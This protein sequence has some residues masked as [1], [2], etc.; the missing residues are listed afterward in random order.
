[1]TRLV[2]LDGSLRP[3][4]GNTAQALSLCISAFGS[5]V[6]V[7]R[8]ALAEYGGSVAE[9][10][11]RL[12]AADGLLVGSGTYWGS[13]GSPL[14]QFLELMTP[15]E[16]TEV[17]LGKPASV[18]V[19]MD[20]TGGSEVAARLAATLVCLGCS[21]PPFGWMS[22]SRIGVALGEHSREAVRDV[23]S[24]ADL[25]VLAGNLV[26]AARAPRVGFRAWSLDRAAPSD[27]PWPVSHSIPSAAPDFL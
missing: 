7:D 2:V 21:T 4:S 11:T 16:A 25:G 27:A 3:A 6:S 9:M 24:A 13:W 14:Q 23:W 8:I 10:A 19:T 20:S 12:R 18:V 1:M 5:D 22:L 15:Y 17:F 26:L